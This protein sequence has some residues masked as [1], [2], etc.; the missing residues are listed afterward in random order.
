MPK[1]MLW[2]WLIAGGILILDQLSKAFV[3]AYVP[4]GS[5]LGWT[6]V[7][8]TH[9]T[10]TGVAFGFFQGTNW[11]FSLIAAIVS[12]LLGVY[13]KKLSQD[14]WLAWGLILGGA[15]GNLVDRLLFGAVTDFIRLG[16]WPSFNAADSA[17]VIGVLLLL[18]QTRKH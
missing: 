8:I 15:I 10:N 1:K 11:I 4:S 5:S 17:L 13:A 14:H 3:R 12:V 18:W 7:A 6:H 16:W 2:Y 9:A